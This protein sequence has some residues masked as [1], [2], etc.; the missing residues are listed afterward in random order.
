MQEH[1]AGVQLMRAAPAQVKTKS[2]VNLRLAASQLMNRANN[3][4]ETFNPTFLADG[5][6][7]QQF[8]ETLGQCY[9]EM[10]QL[11]VQC[12]HSTQDFA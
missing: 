5:S 6:R 3:I 8:V 1:A 12:S 2:L 4:Q 10:H 9:L 11:Q 7:T